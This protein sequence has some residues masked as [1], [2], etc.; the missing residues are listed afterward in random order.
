MTKSSKPSPLTPARFAS[1]GS[2]LF[3]LLV[4]TMAVVVVISSIGATKGVTLGPIITD[5]AFFLFPAA[6]IIGDIISEVYGFKN[7]RYAI[8]MTF[9]LSIFTTLCFW[10]II[11]LPAADWYDGQDALARTL[12]PVWQIVV[13]S[14]L[15]FG[16]G[17]LLNS[18]VL[19]R[20]KQRSGERGLITRIIS[21]S[22]VGE[23]AD[24]AV[25]CAIAAGVI[26]IP[27]AGAFV[28]YVLIGFGYKVGVEVLLSPVTM[29]CIRLV[30]RREPSYQLP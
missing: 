2:Q 18:F 19:V 24:T 14:L 6:Y 5:G 8:I 17:Q 9:G 3:T 22:V 10:V 30:K 12:G 26:G 20:M 11:G 29:W 1:G 16:I 25:F 7:A 13:A 4:A 15:G 23:F 28:N 27:D 21:S